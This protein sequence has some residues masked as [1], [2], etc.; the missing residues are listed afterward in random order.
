MLGG[1]FPDYL[2]FRTVISATAVIITAAYY[3][4]TMQRVFLGKLNAK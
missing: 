2:T 3:L 4:W 1:R